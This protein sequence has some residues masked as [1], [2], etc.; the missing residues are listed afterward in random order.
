MSNIILC[1]SY[2]VEWIVPGMA[3]GHELIQQL[4]HCT[5]SPSI[6]C[7]TLDSVYIHACILSPYTY[8]MHD[9]GMHAMPLILFHNNY[10][11]LQL[12]YSRQVHQQA[13]SR[14]N[15]WSP[16]MKRPK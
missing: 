15:T 12:H 4:L 8:D 3:K 9:I 14:E 11:N 5:P 7:H 1:D 10:G 6:Q 16:S 2:A 13:P